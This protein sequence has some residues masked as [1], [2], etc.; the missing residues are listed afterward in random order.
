MD[1]RSSES[2]AVIL[3]HGFDH[4]IDQ[5]LELEAFDSVDRH[6]LSDGSQ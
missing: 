3:V 2:N 1:L 4:V 6:R 5:S